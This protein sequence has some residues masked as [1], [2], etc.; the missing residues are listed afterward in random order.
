MHPAWASVS[1]LTMLRAVRYSGLLWRRISSANACLSPA[2]IPRTI[3]PSDSG[4]L[5]F[6]SALPGM[7][8]LRK[9]GRFRCGHDIG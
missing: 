9:K 1:S 5:S 7:D 2:A 3:S 4:S 8:V 6:F